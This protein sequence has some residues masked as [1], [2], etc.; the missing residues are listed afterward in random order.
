MNCYWCLRNKKKVKAITYF[1][2]TA[3]CKKHTQEY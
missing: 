3:M 1:K 2:G